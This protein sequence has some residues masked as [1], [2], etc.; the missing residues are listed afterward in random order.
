MQNRSVPSEWCC[1]SHCNVRQRPMGRFASD[2]VMRQHFTA[3]F[4]SVWDRAVARSDDTID[5]DA[6]TG[7]GVNSVNWQGVD[8]I[9]ETPNSATV[10]MHLGGTDRDKDNA[11]F[12]EPK[13]YGCAVRVRTGRST[14][15]LT[16][17]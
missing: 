3:E 16:W 2:L 5:A 7:Q 11:A 8:I 10:E 9:A 13:K 1:G 15:L 17:Q 14:T 12:P 6:F 4:I